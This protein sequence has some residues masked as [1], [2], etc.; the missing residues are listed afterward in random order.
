MKL[1]AVERCIVKLVLSAWNRTV[2]M[3]IILIKP[4]IAKKQTESANAEACVCHAVR[5]GCE[6][7]P[8][9]FE[10]RLLYNTMTIQLRSYLG[11]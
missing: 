4:G 2:R 3:K 1:K 7:V 9:I 6:T 11:Q 10:R 5:A 8:Y